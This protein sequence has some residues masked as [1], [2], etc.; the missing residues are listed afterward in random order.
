MRQENNNDEIR[1][2]NGLLF[3]LR[4]HFDCYYKI[5]ECL[6]TLDVHLSLVNYLLTNPSCVRPRFG[7]DVQLERAF[8]PVLKEI[9][10][11]SGKRNDTSV[12]S[13]DV[14][15]GN[16]IRID[17]RAQFILLTGSNMS[18]KSTFLKELGRITI[19]IRLFILI[20]FI[21]DIFKEI[22]K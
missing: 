7:A 22:Y 1:I 17:R 12:V 21:T 8:H 6:S 19:L 11:G 18:G 3:R 15:I 9:K 4:P 20:L 14:T 2:L 5:S 16:T 10:E 13:T